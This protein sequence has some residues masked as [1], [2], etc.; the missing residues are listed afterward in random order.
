M[1]LPQIPADQTEEEFFRRHVPKAFLR[2]IVRAISQGCI[3]AYEDA[4]ERDPDFFLD[5]I[6]A[7]RRLKVEPILS[8][9]LLPAG[10]ESEIVRTP[11]SHYT[12]ISSDKIVV[13]AVSRSKSVKFVKPY[14]YRST[15]ARGPQESFFFVKDALPKD[16]ANKLFALL[17][18]GGRHSERIPTEARFVF[19]TVSGHIKSDGINLCLE[20]SDIFDSYRDVSEPGNGAE[21]S[22]KEEKKEEG[23][24]E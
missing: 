6:P 8:K 12:M 1:A 9:M 4:S 22:L 20:Y 24:D 5:A 14:K 3:A 18:Y 2:A 23:E 10:F 15:L 11:S 19:P 17:V 7:F 16:S 13:T 21:P